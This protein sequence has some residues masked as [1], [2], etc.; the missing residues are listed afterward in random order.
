MTTRVTR[1]HPAGFTVT[2]ALIAAIVVTVLIA[3]AIPSWRTHQLR[4]RRADA[5]ELLT[6]LQRAQDLHFGREAR[7]AAADQLTAPAPAGLDLDPRSRKGLYL[8]DLQVADDGLG[9]LATARAQPGGVD[10]PRCASLSIDQNGR[11]R[12]ADAAGEDK[13]SDCWR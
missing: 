11:R 1:Q 3:V 7:Y 2:E 6:R 13:S 5:I 4:S 9:Y 10:D 12:A 8:L